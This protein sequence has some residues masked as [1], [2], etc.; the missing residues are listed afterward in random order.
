[1][2]GGTFTLVGATQQPNVLYHL[3][4]QARNLTIDVVNAKGKRLGRAHDLEYLARNSTSTGL[5]R[6]RLGRQLQQGQRHV[7]QAPDGQYK[8]VLS[9]EKPL[10][11][12]H[13]AAHT[14]TWTS[15]SF[16]I[17]RP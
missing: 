5:L 8:L 2:T 17:D 3:D 7:K 1:M 10:A 9:V 15:P 13:N 14:E 6:A 16:T 12:K 11:E 4:H